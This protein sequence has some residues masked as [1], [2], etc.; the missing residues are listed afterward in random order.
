MRD[1]DPL[2]SL[3]AP[4]PAFIMSQRYHK[5]DLNEHNYLDPKIHEFEMM[6]ENMVAFSIIGI[7]FL[8][9]TI[10]YFRLYLKFA[11]HGISSYVN[12][13]LESKIG[14]NTENL[15]G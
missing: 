8:F 5:V 10:R 2:S 1:M 9:L 14:Q 12:T 15:K 6:E 4:V 11:S 3:N 7:S 13:P